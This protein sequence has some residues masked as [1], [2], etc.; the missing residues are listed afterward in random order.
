[1][2]IGPQVGFS[3]TKVKTLTHP[4]TCQFPRFTV[5][6]DHNPP[7]LQ[8]DRQT[9]RRYA[10]SI[11]M[12]CLYD[13]ALKIDSLVTQNHQLGSDFLNKM[14]HYFSTLGKVA[15]RA[16]YFL[17]CFIKDHYNTIRGG[18]ACT[19][20]AVLNTE[21]ESAVD[22]WTTDNDLDHR[23]TRHYRQLDHRLTT[24]CLSTNQHTHTHTHSLTTD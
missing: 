7:T 2:Y 24:D 4:I 10:H 16:I 9:D 14:K 19:H 23:R 17:N 1:L 6:C 13:D 18:M 12:S 15:G 21:A 5:L 20:Y 3:S 8:T 22:M 11:S